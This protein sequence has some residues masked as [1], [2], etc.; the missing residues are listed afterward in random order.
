[1][2]ANQV[3]S[4]RCPNCGSRDRE[5]DS[6][7][8][9][10]AD[11]GWQLEPIE[12]D[13][14]FVPVRSDAAKLRSRAAGRSELGSQITPQRDK[15]ARRLRKYHERAIA[16]APKFVDGIIDELLRTNEPERT[17][18]DAASI[19]DEA[20]SKDRRGSLGR[21]R[22]KCLGFQDGMTKADRTV[23]RQ[24]TFA[25]AALLHMNRDGNPNRA[26]QIADNW[27]LDKVDLL[28][29][30]RLL[31][32]ALRVPPAYRTGESPDE[33]R[34]RQIRHDLYTMRDYLS[35]RLGH[36]QASRVMDTA[37]TILS[38]GGE[39]VEPGS[40]ALVGAFAAYSST[41]AA[42]VAMFEAMKFHGLQADAARF[43]H[44]RVPVWNM[45]V[46]LSGIDSFF[47]RESAEEA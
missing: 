11:C 29:A 26:I 25:A 23:Y 33:F 47:G 17:V 45:N 4:P 15:L 34:G 18:V 3:D 46:F 44:E 1:M 35:D 9:F 37:T 12:A 8:H 28:R 7:H 32:R 20:D 19:I 40:N 10:C 41:K 21:K 38:E 31:R 2:S 36:A 27:N 39:P 16:K 5:E 42:M 13:S 14:G 24:R 43:L 6:T 22:A 30:L